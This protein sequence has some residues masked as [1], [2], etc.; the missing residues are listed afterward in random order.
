MLVFGG[1]S[2]YFPFGQYMVGMFFQGEN[3]LL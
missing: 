3:F 1:G 2:Y